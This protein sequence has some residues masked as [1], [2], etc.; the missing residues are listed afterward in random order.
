MIVLYAASIFTLLAVIFQ[1]AWYIYVS[2][3]LAL[4]VSLYVYD[5]ML[6]IAMDSYDV[7]VDNMVEITEEAAK[8]L[9]H[10]PEDADISLLPLL[11][12]L[13]IDEIDEV[14]E[15]IVNHY[16]GKEVNKDE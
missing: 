13:T 15:Y 14:T 10:F 12:T 4:L 11:S 5:Y 1:W 16:Y 8:Q 3:I 7:M 2:I 6:D 9:Y